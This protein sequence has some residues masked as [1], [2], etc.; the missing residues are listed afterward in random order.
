VRIRA[1]LREAWAATWAAKVS[2]VLIAV[3]VAGMC[4]AAIA[5]VG[6][7]AA[8]S[9]DVAARMEQAGA[10]RLQVIDAKAEGFI[11]ARTL[12]VISNLSSVES[13]DALGIPF[14]A[15]NGA[16][17][18]GGIRIPVWPVLGSITQIGTLTRG[19]LPQPGEALISATQLATL[20]LEQPVGFLVATDGTASYPIVGAYTARAPFEDLAG[21][22]IV[23]R[24]DGTGREL[25]VVL[26]SVNATDG[27][28]AAVMNTLAPRDS[29]G[30][31]VDS[32]AALAQTARDLADQLA[33]YGSS[34]LS[35][36]LG[37]GG[38]LVAAVVLADV[39]VRRRDLGRRRT[40]GITRADLTAIV[41]VRAATTAVIGALLGCTAGWLA[42]HA[43]GQDTP[44]S[45]TVAVGVLATIVAALA[46]LPPA[47]YATRLD[48]V[49]VMRTP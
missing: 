32:P 29:Q 43:I 31:Q 34:L 18:T 14:D 8:A 39:L 21:G 35:L 6:R 10:R 4:V 11:N 20:G 30:V 42:N 38:S 47:V 44:L 45:F 28:V 49:T 9:A 3:V 5:T 19:R 27:T 15:T 48:P 17:G 24:P 40:L 41:I 13:A 23:A 22:A 37:A 46:A 25:R 33:G 2:S 7:S 12:G 26:N 1:L 16:T 36:I